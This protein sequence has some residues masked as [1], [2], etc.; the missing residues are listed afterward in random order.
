M[1]STKKNCSVELRFD[2]PIAPSYVFTQLSKL[3][4]VAKSHL[5]ALQPL[6]SGQFVLYFK[7]VELLRRFGSALSSISG[8]SVYGG[9]G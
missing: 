1:A 9:S 2:N 8:C 4:I 3:G 5:W 7:S 6:K